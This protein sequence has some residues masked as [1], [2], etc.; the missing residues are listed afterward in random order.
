[1]K[2]LYE[3]KIA[4]AH[5][6][7]LVT[8]VSGDVLAIGEEIDVLT[9]SAFA[10]EYTPTPSSLFGV[11]YNVGIDISALAENPYID[12][13]DRCDVWLSAKIDTECG[14]GRIG[15]VELRPFIEKNALQNPLDAIRAYFSM[16]DVAAISGASMKT[17][18]MPLLG[19][20]DQGVSSSLTL[21]PI[22]NECL[23]FLKRNNACE[24]IIFFDIREERAAEF[25]TALS[26]LYSLTDAPDGVE[27]KKAPLAFI[28]YSSK[29]K[30]V[31]DNLC[32][33]LEGWGIRV[34]YAPR[35]VVGPYAS[36]IMKGI[37]EAD[38]FIVIVSHNSLASQHV[39]NEIDNAHSRLPDLKFKP[40]RLEDMALTPEFSYYLSRQHWLD[41]TVPPLEARLEA[42]VEDILAD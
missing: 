15:C 39:L 13:R 27:A 24:K 3:R 38:Y 14:I 1:M 19:A 16:L 29:D 2:T 32:N 25:A 42:F 7:K 35:N 34:W 8:V 5:G 6:E 33:K 18:A 23:S 31:A 17:L 22:V 28:S 9:V 4:T 30:N 21:I 37:K 40:L 41:A 10:R 20:G 36:A 26:E 12:L 11:M